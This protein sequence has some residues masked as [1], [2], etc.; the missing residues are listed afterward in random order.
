MTDFGLKIKALREEQNKTREEICGDESELSVR[1]LARIEQGQSIP[2]LAK[3]IYISN[4]LGVSLSSITED[5]EF[6]LPKRYKELKHLILR[7]PTYKDK[8]KVRIREKQFDEIFIHFYDDLPEEEKLVVDGLQASL[9]VALSKNINFG[10]DILNDYFEQIKVKNCFTRNDL[11]IIDLYLICVRTSKFSDAI[12]DPAIY[13]SLLKKTIAQIDCAEIDDF[14]VLN[15]VLITFYTISIQLDRAKELELIISNCN[16][17]MSIVN[18]FYR[19]PILYVMEWKY[20]IKYLDDFKKATSF[21]H[22]AKLF[23]QMTGDS[24][25][26]EKIENEW[27]RDCQ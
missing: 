17:I 22:K 18:D 7:T 21:Y 20:S 23:A 11:I 3:A 4:E 19:M 8:E 10:S 14:Y 2:S 9:D 26:A 16:R 6:D 1:Q 27:R 24:D 25:L 13:E 15:Q 5:G 12:Y